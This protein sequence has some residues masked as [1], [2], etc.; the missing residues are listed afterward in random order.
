MEYIREK[1]YSVAL[2][3]IRNLEEQRDELLGIVR[4]I[5]VINDSVNLT[6]KLVKE[7]ATKYELII[8][9]EEKDPKPWLESSKFIKDGNLDFADKS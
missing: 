7:T 2:L 4:Q 1:H 9:E 5:N 8:L 6:K 3:K